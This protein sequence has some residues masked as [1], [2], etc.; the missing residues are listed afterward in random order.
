MSHAPRKEE[1]LAE[2]PPVSDGEAPSTIFPVRR[3]LPGETIYRPGERKAELFFLIEGAVK[4]WAEQPSPLI[5]DIVLPGEV[6]GDVSVEADARHEERADPHTAC[7]VRA[8]PVEQIL[9]KHN[10]SYSAIGLRLFKLYSRKA[11]S[12]R[13]HWKTVLFEDVRRRLARRLI[14]LLRQA[15]ETSGLTPLPVR[16]RQEDLACM[17]GSTRVTI[18]QTLNEFERYGLVELRRSLIR[19]D[20]AKLREYLSMTE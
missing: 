3:Y 11:A 2:R 10:P 14:E 20:R 6:F 12:A 5:L 19:A 13:L 17:V 1:R 4:V 18:C 9:D 16:L 7:L 8:F 15:P